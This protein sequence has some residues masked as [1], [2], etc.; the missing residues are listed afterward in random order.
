MKYNFDFKENGHWKGNGGFD[1]FDS[2]Q[3]C[4]DYVKSCKENSHPHEEQYF[5]LEY[6]IVEYPELEE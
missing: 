6:I 5:K 3:D 4:L 1:D 2:Y